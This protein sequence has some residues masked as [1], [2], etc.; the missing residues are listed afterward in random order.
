MGRGENSEKTAEAENLRQQNGQYRNTSDRLSSTHRVKKLATFIGYHPANIW[1]CD[2]RQLFD[3]RSAP[4]FA[5][6]IMELGR[7]NCGPRPSIELAHGSS[8]ATAT[9]KFSLAA[10]RVAG[11]N[12]TTI[13]KTSVRAPNMDAKCQR[14]LGSVRRECLD[15]VLAFGERQ[16]LRTLRERI[17]YH[18]EL[19]PH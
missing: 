17:G 19:R 16:L 1:S 10:D 7:S 12:G 6:L 5:F 4:I 8:S 9:Q 3:V 15:H 14:P 18:N 2:F 11:P 13:V